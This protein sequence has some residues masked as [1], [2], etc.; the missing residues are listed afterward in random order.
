MTSHDSGEHHEVGGVRRAPPPRPARADEPP[1]TPTVKMQRVRWDDP[2]RPPSYERP[3]AKPAQRT[4]SLPAHLPHVSPKMP[5]PPAI[6]EPEIDEPPRP[7]PAPLP[8]R[9]PALGRHVS[10]G[11]YRYVAPRSSSKPPRRD[12]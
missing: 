4:A 12:K 9:R 3:E 2:D 11:E 7:P 6:D 8:P 1:K 10:T 5:E